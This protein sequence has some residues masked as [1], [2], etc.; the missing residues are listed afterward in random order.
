MVHLGRSTCHAISGRGDQ[1]SRIPECWERGS[2]NGGKVF[3]FGR[4]AALKNRLNLVSGLG[5]RGEGFG[6][7]GMYKWGFGFWVLG[8]W[9]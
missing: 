6:Y 7:E 2:K 5:L 1:S 4:V 8:F 9:V 3:G